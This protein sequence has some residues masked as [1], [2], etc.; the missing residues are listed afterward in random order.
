[1]GFPQRL[2][3][4]M[5]DKSVKGADLA[6]S[7]KVQRQAVYNWLAGRADPTQ[8]NLRELAVNLDVEQ[9]WLAT[10][11]KAKP[12]VVSGLELHGDAAGGVWMEIPENQDR[13]F[14]RVP[15]APDP[16]YPA[17]CQYALKVRGTSVNQHVPDG[18][19]IVCVDIAHSG[20]SPRD[21]DLVVVERRRGG[22]VE[23]TVKQL[24]KGAGGPELWPVSTDP[25]HQEK[26][27]IG[28]AKGMEVVMKAIVIWTA[29][30]VPRGA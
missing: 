26:L 30:R 21:R 9:D 10:G 28:R 29:N 19:I 18:G 13:E 24:R 11:R 4:A 17:D 25:E 14:P 23:T 22:M 16:D 1:M 20:I 5:A 15:V 7:L 12:G 3:K 2:R 8:D 27:T 6:R